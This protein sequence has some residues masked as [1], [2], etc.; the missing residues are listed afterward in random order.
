[1]AMNDDHQISSHRPM[2]IFDFPNEVLLAI[3]DAMDKNPLRYYHVRSDMSSN[4]I[5]NFR[6]TCRR[7]CEVSSH[8]LVRSVKVHFTQSSL[9]LLEEIS[10]HPTISKGVR[11]VEIYLTFYSRELSQNFKKF[12]KYYAKELL[13]HLDAEYGT[14]NNFG[15]RRAWLEGVWQAKNVHKSWNRIID[16]KSARIPDPWELIRGDGE[17]EDTLWAKEEDAAHK[18]LL[19]EAHRDY[20]RLYAEQEAIR[21]SGALA[22]AVAAAMARMPLARTLDISDMPNHFPGQTL[23]EIPARRGVGIDEAYYKV[24][25]MPISGHQAKRR[26]LQ[27]TNLYPALVEIPLAIHRAGVCIEGFKIVVAGMRNTDVLRL[28]AAAREE[29]TSA[30]QRLGVF[31]FRGSPSIGH[32]RGVPEKAA[33]LDNFLKSCLS[34]PSLKDLD[35]DPC[36]RDGPL[37]LGNE[38]DM[39]ELPSSCL[40]VTPAIPRKK[41]Q[42]VSLWGA[43]FRLNE[44]MSVLS[45]LPSKMESLVFSDIRLTDGTWEE[46]LDALRKKTY[47]AEDGGDG[48]FLVDLKGGEITDMTD[49]YK[50]IIF[51]KG[52]FEENNLVEDYVLRHTR[53]NP[54]REFRLGNIDP[55]GSDDSDEFDDSDE[56]VGSAGSDSDSL[57]D[58]IEVN[59]SEV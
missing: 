24:M 33:D 45:S 20:Q 16:P 22:Q 59:D 35:L 21:Q 40:A 38:E 19:V 47:E 49:Y 1:M 11:D 23:W 17:D 48:V 39:Y 3:L 34:T 51:G 9:S 58:L 13:D 14:Q 53:R 43:K 30:M 25:R 55:D 28:D 10:Q 2:H 18:A 31:Q 50:E 7:F 32:G 5:I 4:P 57:P 6:M 37:V 29:L 36:G 12:V 42:T 56:L 15:G 41:L 46:V 27:P 44:L 52:E 8:L 54:L 26:G